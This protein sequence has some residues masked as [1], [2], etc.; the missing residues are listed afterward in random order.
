MNFKIGDTVQAK[1]ITPYTITTNGWIGKVRRVVSSTRIGVQDP[2]GGTIFDVQSKYFT[3]YRGILSRPFRVG[4]RIRL[5]DYD[6]YDDYKEHKGEIAKIEKIDTKG[7]NPIR[8]RWH[9][10]NTS[11]TQIQN[12]VLAKRGTGKLTKK[13]GFE[14]GDKVRVTNHKEGDCGKPTCAAF[15]SSMKKYIGKK[16]TIKRVVRNKRYQIKE[17]G[18]KWTW[19]E[20]MFEEGIEKLDLSQF[21]FKG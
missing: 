8:I 5:K 13:T 15:V 4:D 10:K 18:G 20:C 14:V 6:R 19:S 21:D 11:Y 1:K 17:D 16:V 7:T 12:M 9:D 2:S 3:K